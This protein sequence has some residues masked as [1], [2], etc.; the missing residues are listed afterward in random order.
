VLIRAGVERA[1]ILAIA[2]TDL[3]SATAAIRLARRLNPRVRVIALADSSG[4]IHALEAAGANEV[5]QPEFEASMGFVRQALRWLG[6]TAPQA[7]NVIVDE[8]HAFYV[9]DSA[10]P[11]AAR[12]N[13][14]RTQQKPRTATEAPI[15]ALGED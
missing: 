11:V 5:V 7:R 10:A 12:R 15:L 13:E 8:R 1:S 4:E 3:V 14:R 9:H 2:I 6:A